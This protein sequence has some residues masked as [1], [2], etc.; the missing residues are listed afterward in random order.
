MEL[1]RWSDATALPAGWTAAGAVLLGACVG[2]F[3][4]VVAHRVPRG[5]SV[6]RPRSRCPG[7][8][9]PV[10]VRDNVP[11][12]SWLLL[13][14]RCRHCGAPISLRYPLVE[15]AGA[16]VAAAA[17]LF[18]PT[19]RQAVAGALLGWWLLALLVTDL[20]HRLLPDAL[21][22]PGIVAGLI[23]GPWLGTAR[24]DALLG[25]AGGYLAL[26]ALQR[27]YAAWRGRE[28]LG[29]GDVKLAAMLGAWLG[30]QGVLLT[31]LLG[32]L[33]GS[34]TGLALAATRRIDAA[35]RLPYGAFLVPA[36]GIV[37]AWGHRLWEWY[38]S[39]GR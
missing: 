25:A 10:A 4:N 3:L 34:V 9:A 19:P 28:G 8:G 6:V 37:L 27:G 29:G 36:A 2:S 38:L 39:L 32:S 16:A 26:L 35:T 17:V 18:A 24:G 15:L 21:T 14:G 7:C 5:E 31:F 13:Q 1:L 22:L 23:L 12:L 30:W 20:E 33:T 11:V